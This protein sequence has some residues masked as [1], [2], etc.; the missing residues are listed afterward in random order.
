MRALILSLVAGVVVLSPSTAADSKALERLWEFELKGTFPQAVV[1]DAKDKQYLY[2]ALKNGGLGVLKLGKAGDPPKEIARLPIEQFGKLDVM[3]LTQRGELLYLALGDFFDAKGAHAG[4]AIVSIADRAAPKVLGQ[5][6]SPKPVQGSA[7]VLVDAKYAYLGAMTE[8]VMIFDITNPAK[9]KHMSTFQPDVGFPKPKPTKIQHPNA[10]GMA[11]VGDKLYLAYD[12]GGL[13]ILDVSKRQQPREL[14]RYVNAGMKAKQQAYNNIVIDGDTAYAAIDY[15]GLEVLNIKNPAE[16][17]QVGWWNPW[18]ADTLGNL[19]LN[20]PGHTNQLAFDKKH[21]LVYLSAGASELQ[22]V[23]VSDPK[24]PA[25]TQHYGER[26]NDR[27]VWGV[28]LDGDVAYLT[29]V[30]A[31]IPFRGTWSGIVAVKVQ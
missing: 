18:K 30:T 19:W 4:L 31:V 23:D 24:K 5:W 8:G 3:H 1:V 13:R 12:A 20:S 2:V 14:G 26:K 6:T 17:K 9:I 27:G 22:V 11:L 10:R 16:I 21:N 29:Y 28:T 15:A 7:I 25:L